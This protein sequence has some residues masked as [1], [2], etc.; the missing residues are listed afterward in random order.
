MAIVRNP[1]ALAAFSLA[2]VATACSGTPVAPDLSQHPPVPPPSSP[3]PQP[4][5]TTS[6]SLVIDDFSVIVQPSTVDSRGVAV[7]DGWFSLEVRFALRETGGNSG[8][9]VQSFFLGDGA[10]GGAWYDGFCIGDLRVPPGG[11][12]DTLNTDEG[13]ESWSYCAPYWGTVKAPLEEFSVFLDVKFVD[14]DGRS[15]SVRAKATW[16]KHF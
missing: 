12:Y 5:P 9:T 6:A 3:S 11:V 8:A 1:V 16:K 13:Y 15:G 4:L 7:V 2:I 14:D 10:G